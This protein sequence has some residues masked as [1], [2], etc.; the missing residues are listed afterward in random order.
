MCFSQVESL[1]AQFPLLPLAVSFATVFP[2]RDT[3]VYDRLFIY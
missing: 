1:N 2:S 3:P